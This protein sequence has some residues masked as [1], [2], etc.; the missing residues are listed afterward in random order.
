MKRSP[1]PQRAAPLRRT[2]I[3]SAVLPGERRPAGRGLPARSPKRRAQE[4]EYDR[5]KGPWLAERPYCQRCGE[6]SVC[7]HHRAG[8]EGL[9][10]IEQ[11]WWAA[12]CAAC[13][14]F[15]ETDTGAALDER[16]LLSYINPE[17]SAA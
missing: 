13:N 15:A 4:R 1:M 16:W 8:R 11:R 3:R 2:E 17:G 5:L 14:D 7:V 10:L 9:R 12:S 6:P